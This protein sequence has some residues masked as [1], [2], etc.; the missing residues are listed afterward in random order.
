M[1]NPP[2]HIQIYPRRTQGDISLNS[3]FIEKKENIGRSL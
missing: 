1:T 2:L 3:T